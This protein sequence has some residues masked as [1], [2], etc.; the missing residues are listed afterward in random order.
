MIL[1]SVIQ[2]LQVNMLIIL[3]LVVSYVRGELCPTRMFGQTS[4]VFGENE[5]EEEEAIA[6]DRTR[7]SFYRLSLHSVISSKNHMYFIVVMGQLWAKKLQQLLTICCQNQD[8]T[9]NLDLLMMG[10]LCK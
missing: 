10:V 6:L 8:M 3:C 1:A 7:R 4:V 2:A 9:E 5:L